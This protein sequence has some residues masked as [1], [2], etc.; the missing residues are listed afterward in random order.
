M[1][2]GGKGW[3]RRDFVVDKAVEGREREGVERNEKR[4]RG[5]KLRI[6]EGGGGEPK[7]G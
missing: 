5:S 7:G 2:P 6:G 1:V 3:S 4:G